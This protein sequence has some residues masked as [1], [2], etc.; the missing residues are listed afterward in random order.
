MGTLL[1]RVCNRGLPTT[2]EALESERKRTSA[3]KD[4]NA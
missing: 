4:G 1:Q 3:A 2:S